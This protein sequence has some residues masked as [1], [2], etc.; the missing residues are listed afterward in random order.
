MW[1]PLAKSDQ[2]SNAGSER[3]VSGSSAAPQQEAQ[4]P[5]SSFNAKNTCEQQPNLQE[6]KAQPLGPEGQDEPSTPIPEAKEP[7]TQQRDDNESQASGPAGSSGSGIFGGLKSLG[8]GLTEQVESTV[9]NVPSLATKQLDILKDLPVREGGEIVGPDGNI[10]GRVV[11]GGE[12][13][14]GGT[15][16]EGGKIVNQAGQIIG[17]A[18]LADEVKDTVERAKDE[19][20]HEELE[21]AKDETVEKTGDVSEMAEQA[22]DEIGD[23]LPPLTRLEGLTCNKAGKI[24]DPNSGNPIGELVE[25]DPKKLFKLGSKLDHKG[26]FWDSRGNVI[27]KA[28]T[29]VFEDQGEEPPFAGLEGLQVVE[30]GFVEDKNGRRVGK[31]TEGDAKK[32]IGRPVDEDGD[33]IDQHG[34]VKG[35]AEPYEEPE[36]EQPEEEDLSILDGKTVNKAGKVVDEHGKVYGRIVEGDGKRLAGKKV[37]GKGQIWGDNGK[38]IGKAELIPGAEEEKPEG[39]F[40][41]F[42][43]LTVRKDGTVQDGSGRVV[44]R[45]IEG[46][47]A[48]LSG[49][50][51]DEDG[52]ILDRN[53]NTIG[54]AERWEPEE[55]KRDVNPMAG[56][57]ITREGEVRDTDGNLIGKLT[58]GNLSQLI[59]KEIDD[60]GY[61]VDNDGN[62]IGEATLLEHIPEPEE[63]EPE[64]EP[65]GPSAEELEAQKKEQEDRDLAKKMSAI[66]SQTLDRVAPICRM[67]TEHIDRAERTPKDE[68]DEEQLVKDVKP[69]LEEASSYLQECNGAIRALDPDGRIANNAKARAAS[70]EA[71]PE[72]Y[73]LADKLKELTDTVVRTIDNGKKKIS[74]MPHAKK[75]LNPLWGLLSEPLFQIIAAVGLLLSGVLGL[76]GRLLEGLGLGPLVNGLLGGLGLDRLLSNLGLTSLTDALGLT[77]KKK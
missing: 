76:V 64:P 67:I 50:K 70:H 25:G 28:K 29:V 44:G 47:V 1:S 45:V 8:G 62:K 54:R 24:I 33:V 38:V 61:V 52:D 37:D 10:V 27:G 74:G 4:N 49:R 43:N 65:E 3:R 16:Q 77:G 31:L 55:K 22:A 58:S 21:S 42:E 36:E 75:E 32:L 39:A 14:V 40:Y 46:D 30:N 20:P 23:E 51:V 9:K 5:D 57:K 68:L 48:K 63:P 7:E 15:V 11:E 59:G 2:R 26:Q 19:N 6:Q 66:I 71:S 35:H 41:A 13:A 34:S 56:R 17:R 53:G 12:E 18:E 73:M 60:N 69:L 72:E